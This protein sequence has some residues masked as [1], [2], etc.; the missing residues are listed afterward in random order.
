MWV[1]YFLPTAS[2]MTK[3]SENTQNTVP[4]KGTVPTLYTLRPS[5]ELIIRRFHGSLHE[6]EPSFHPIST[7]GK[8]PKE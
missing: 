7:S 2:L 3:Q 1:R 6:Q 4:C 5:D 8:Q